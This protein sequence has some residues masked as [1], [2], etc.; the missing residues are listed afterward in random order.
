[1]RTYLKLTNYLSEY[2]VYNHENLTSISFWNNEQLTMEE[3][4]NE[5]DLNERIE[6]EYSRNEKVE[7]IDKKEFNEAYV[8]FTK[9]LNQLGKE[10]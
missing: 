7:V 5:E 6:R 1:M 2:I 9:K 4:D 8:A 3:F 10:L